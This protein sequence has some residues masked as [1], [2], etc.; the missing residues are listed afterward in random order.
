M[1]KKNEECTS[2]RELEARV[3]V[4]ENVVLLL[5]GSQQTLHISK[6]AALATEHQLAGVILEEYF[7]TLFET[8][9]DKEQIDQMAQRLLDRNGIVEE[10]P[11]HQK[12]GAN[13]TWAVIASG[14]KHDIRRLKRMAKD[15]PG[16]SAEYEQLIE[17]KEA[18]LEE[19]SKKIYRTK[20]DA[21]IAA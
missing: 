19:I 9:P 12:S 20:P 5:M 3:D 1:R 2:C 13:M 21:P 15:D 7:P 10:K 8:R 6:A 14:L 4:L 16:Q 11:V 17:T 18:K